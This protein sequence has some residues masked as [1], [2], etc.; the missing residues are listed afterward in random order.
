MPSRLPEFK[1]WVGDANAPSRKWVRDVIFSRSEF[2]D[3][4][5]L[6]V[7]CGLAV[8]CSCYDFGSL[9]T[10][11]EYVGVESC[12][13]FYREN[14]SRGINMI[15]SDAKDLPLVDG[16]FEFV[17]AR[18]VLDHYEHLDILGEMMRVAHEM[19][20]HTFFIPPHSLP[21][22]N[23]PTDGVDHV[24]HSMDELRAIV[25]ENAEFSKVGNEVIMVV[26]L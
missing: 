26:S 4:S 13:F 2:R 1:E 21:R 5:V 12:D 7:G 15:Y 19:V 23:C 20:I 17:I 8:D 24:T 16:A 6:D 10:D 18:H 22:V 14:V 9:D 3:V 25:G 11:I